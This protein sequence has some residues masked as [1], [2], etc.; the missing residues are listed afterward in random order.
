R[1]RSAES[2]GRDQ[3][4]PGVVHGSLAAPLT[5]RSMLLRSDWGPRTWPPVD[6]RVML[7]QAL[8]IT[9]IACLSGFA[10]LGYEIVWT[11]MLAVSLGHEIVAVLGVISAL[12]AGLALGS[13]MPGRRI[14]ASARPALW[15][16]GLELA[17]GVWALF[18]IPL[19]PLAGDLVP[20]LVPVDAPPARQ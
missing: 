19:S 18:L 13:L 1:L 16:A 11:R 6:S 9:A 8:L 2:A 10:G 14:A 17:I 15:Y 4:R 5:P 7:K 20:T 3:C 12:F